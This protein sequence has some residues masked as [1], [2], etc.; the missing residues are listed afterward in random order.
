MRNVASIALLLLPF[1]VIYRG[2]KAEAQQPSG[3]RPSTAGPA[4]DAAY[5]ASAGADTGIS[6]RTRC[7]RPTALRQ[8]R[9]RLRAVATGSNG[10]TTPSGPPWTPPPT[11]SGAESIRYTNNS[12]DTLRFVW[13]QLDQNLFRPGAPARCFS[14]RRAGSA[15]PGSKVASKS[16]R[17]ANAAGRRGR[18]T[19]GRR[20]RKR[21][22]PPKK[23][24][25]TAPT[26]Y[27]AAAWPA[28]DPGGRHHDVV[29]LATPSPREP[30][31]CRAG[32]TASTSP[33]TAPTAWAARAACTRWRNGIRAWRS[34]TTCTAGIPTRTWA[35]ASSISS[36]A[37]STTR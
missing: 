16:T 12:P 22:K 29:D 17:S 14:R 32:R 33:S 11:I 6:V 8:R 13:M 30:A 5:P 25:E 2:E 18:K 26:P 35:R 9:W 23:R 20:R 4:A 21:A 28:Q 37:T 31:R 19:A 24:V 36:T 7:R 27:P 10:S 1:P 15:E 3:P 34:T